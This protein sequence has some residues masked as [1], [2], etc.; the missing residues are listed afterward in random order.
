M[1]KDNYTLV[2]RSSKRAYGT[3]TD[4]HIDCGEFFQNFN[5]QYLN[6]QL[7]GWVFPEDTA[8][9]S[10]TTDKSLQV[11]ANL[12]L[13]YQTDTDQR[14]LNTLAILPNNTDTGSSIH[15]EKAGHRFTCQI[16]DGNMVHVRIEN[17]SSEALGEDIEEHVLV[18][19]FAP[20]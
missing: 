2:L 13:P 14:G 3:T 1:C 18:L 6:G 8:D 16:P 9:H 11:K 10:N 12:Q 20:V 5:N 19:E 7:V 17:A 15:C 4:Y